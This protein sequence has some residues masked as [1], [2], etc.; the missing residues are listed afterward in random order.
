[1]KVKNIFEK[2]T[3]V[4]MNI[5]IFIF[6]IILLISIYNNIQVKILGNDYASFFGYSLF[7]V[8][9]GS[10]S[11][12]IEAG[13]W[14]VVKYDRNIEV[15]DIITFKQNG[16]FITHRVIESYN[17]T[18]I[19][20]GDVNNTED[21]PISKEQ[22]VGEVVKIL[23]GFGI[24]RNT[25]FNPFVLIA[26][27]I[28]LY[29]FGLAFKKNKTDDKVR[30]IDV[31]MGKIVDLIKNIFKNM[32]KKPNDKKTK[33]VI[34]ETKNNSAEPELKSVSIETHEQ[35]ISKN[36]IEEL[37]NTETP[38]EDMD[39][40]IYFRKIAVDKD[41]IE[42]A[43]N[44]IEIEEPEVEIEE[45]TKEETVDEVKSNLEMLQKKKKFKNIIEKIMYIKNEEIKEMLDILNMHEKLKTNEP[46]I[47]ETLLKAYIDAK[48]YNF[49]GDINVEYNG[50]NMNTSIETALKNVADKMIKQYKGSDDKFSDK[51][52]KYTNLF[53]LV[54]HL[55]QIYIAID[56]LQLKKQTYKNKIVKTLSGTPLT[57]NLLKTMITQLIKTQRK[58]NSM[59]KYVLEKLET[60]IFELKFNPLGLKN[61]YGVELVHN[62]N[63]SR[64]YSDY[65]VDKTYQ[66]GIVA[67]DKMAVLINLL[68]IQVVKDM[69]EA[70]FNKKYIIYIPDSLYSKENKLDNI[71][72]I[73]EDEYAKNNIIVLVKYE[74]LNRKIIKKYVKEGYHFAISLENNEVKPKDQGYIEL[75]DY[76]FLDKTL[77]RSVLNSIDV[78][79]SI[80]EDLHARVIYDDIASKVGDLWG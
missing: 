43:Y 30:K 41:E 3:N 36:E 51:V 78:L 58:H 80:P 10:M 52:K 76:I 17:G 27:I 6:G 15:D 12:T 16:E 11:G 5:L 71:F 13:D 20:K 22:I 67:E 35:I 37:E 25:L 79:S 18:Y 42:S 14:I 26:L 4:I 70:D 55:E 73:F 31:F 46:T 72:E 48:Y 39:K 64:V 69:L 53:T 21:E 74:N 8:Q 59:T 56:D 62:I 23:P 34:V 60:S 61:V 33:K 50:R 2:V 54:M 32:T 28:T 77:K 66:E 38:L 63:F 57:P 49:C 29:L 9:T 44:K 68:L 24:I 19:T 1:M 65:V 40:T 7:E 75:M 47:R 45:S